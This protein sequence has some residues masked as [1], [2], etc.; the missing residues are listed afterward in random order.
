MTQ[1]RMEIE[2]KVGVF[3]AIG[4]GLVMVAILLLG[5]TENVLS[6]KVH[7]NVHLKNV[8]G[9]V[10]GAKV[11]LGGI[12]IGTIDKVSFDDAT[13]DIRVDLKITQKTAKYIKKDSD[14]E[15]STQ[16][17]LGDKFLSISPGEDESPSLPPG[18]EIQIRPSKGISQFLSQSDQLMVRLNSVAASV[19]RLLKEF[20]SGSR[21]DKFFQ[22]M[23]VTARNL[24]SATEKLDHE[25]DGV[26]LKKIVRNLESITDKI[27]NGTGT[28]GALIN[29]P[30]LY[31]NAKA[32]VGEANRNRIMR[33]LVRQTLKDSNAAKSSSSKSANKP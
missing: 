9:L 7:Y 33:N 11:M 30:T 12:Q 32:L 2:L 31:D 26:H 1:H 3:V 16:G 14:A 25:I 10:S 24:A 17:V 29:D 21:S 28:V 6:R 15:I 20:E 13:K 18:S 8:E 19:D 5:S 23:T 27:N 22:G 4:L